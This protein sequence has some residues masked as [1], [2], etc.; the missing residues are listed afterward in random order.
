MFLNVQRG[1]GFRY[2]LLP[3]C[4]GAGGVR[5]L[6]AVQGRSRRSHWDVAGV[7]N[8]YILIP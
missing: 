7:S 5:R 1:G 3:I 6:R 8:P 2:V 4:D